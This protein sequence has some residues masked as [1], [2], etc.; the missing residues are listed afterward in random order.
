MK[1]VTFVHHVQY[2]R[3]PKNGLPKNGQAGI[4]SKNKNDP[5]WK[6]ELR[7]VSPQTTFAVKTTSSA[8]LL[9]SKRLH[10]DRSKHLSRF[11]GPA[12]AVCVCNID[13]EYR[14]CATRSAMWLDCGSKNKN[15]IGWSR[16]K[17]E[18]SRLGS[19]TPRSSA[20][21]SNVPGYKMLTQIF[22]SLPRD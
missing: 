9:T 12:C 3:V 5:G 6:I 1:P 18:R 10:V 8:A 15:E 20:P 21:D 4:L 2:C 22:Y 16:E 14:V 17:K 7:T 19:S 11:P 13:I